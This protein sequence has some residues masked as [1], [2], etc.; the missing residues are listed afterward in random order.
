[1][2]LS[3]CL[4]VLYHL[5]FEKA[6]ATAADLGFEAV[7]LAVDAKSPFVSLE[8]CLEDRGRSLKRALQDHGLRLSA[9]SNHQEGQLLLGPHGS[10][11]D[12]IFSGRPE[13][14]VAYASQRLAQS[15][16][17]AEMLEV[18]VLCGFTGCE[19]YSRW[20]PWPDV[21]AYG[22][23][24][25]ILKE[26]LLPLLDT[27]QAHGV[28]FAHECH[29]RQFAYNLE[30]AEWALELLDHHPGF[31][32]NFDPANLMLAG[33]D[34]VVFAETL[35]PRIW[36]GH[37]K[38]GELVAQHAG[39]SG[40]LAHGPWGRPGRGFRFRIP[41]WGDLNW[42]RLITALHVGGFT[43]HLALEHEDPTMSRLEG[44][45]QG[46]RFLA[47]LLLREPPE[48]GRWW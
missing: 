26:R 21:G 17:L 38:D 15:A 4:Q 22:A 12:G 34:P 24:G 27:F 6:L 19:D 43:G 39:R 44:L 33:M 16:A 31:G 11:T 13:E 8:A 36:H 32:F 40:L 47:P 9:L 20:F 18:E 37:A 28:R 2:E 10:D 23:M 45:R 30:T 3:L 46:Q 5:P 35:A 14:K 25:P 48:E 7:E 29:P 42:R 41:G 1:M